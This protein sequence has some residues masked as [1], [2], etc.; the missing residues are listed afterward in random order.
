M[1]S[2]TYG[3]RDIV[4]ERIEQ[5]KRVGC[6]M[7]D[8]IDNQETLGLT[9]ELVAFVGEV[10]LEG[11]AGTTSKVL[12]LLILC[13]GCYPDV[14]RRAQEEIDEVIGSSRMPT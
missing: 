11:G 6:F 13:L 4:L 7:E 2:V 12:R 10:C 9:D 1:L 8:L 3:L 5:N 14:Q